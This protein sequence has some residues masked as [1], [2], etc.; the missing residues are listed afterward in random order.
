[1][2]ADISRVMIPIVVLAMAVTICRPVSADAHGELDSSEFALYHPSLIYPVGLAS[3]PRVVDNVLNCT[4]VKD[5]TLFHLTLDL[6]QCDGLQIYFDPRT[7]IILA[8]RAT[9][10]DF[11][12]ASGISVGDTRTTVRQTYGDP[13]F[14]NDTNDNY[15]HPRRSDTVNLIFEYNAAGEVTMISIHW[16]D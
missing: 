2:K 1:M 15:I 11:S 16:L 12:T 7:T 13:Y 14:T 10:A 3:N 6:Y 5:A 9:H 8:I 4:L